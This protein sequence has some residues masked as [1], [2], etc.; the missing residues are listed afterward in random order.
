M[1][2]GAAGPPDYAAMGFPFSRE[3]HRALML[4]FPNMAQFGL[5][6]SDTSRGSVRSAPGAS[7]RINYDLNDADLRT[8]KRGVEL[9]C[10]LYWAAGAEELYPPIEGMGVL[11]GG[12]VDTVR[13]HDL[14]PRDLTLMAFH[15]LGTARADARPQHGVVDGDLRLHGTEGLYVC[16]ASVIPSSLGVN[17]QITIMA[18]ATRLAY[19]LLGKPAPDDEPEPEKIAQP[20]ITRLHHVTA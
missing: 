1:F 4:D 6:V 10:E 13:N 18:L 8:F 14:R 19:H 15:P 11:R 17:P 3:R 7:F 2:E 12:D 16:D 20:R 9:L 5:M